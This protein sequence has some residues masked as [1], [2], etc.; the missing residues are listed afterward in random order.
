MDGYL[1]ITGG[2]GD[3]DLQLS[4]SFALLVSDPAG[5]YVLTQKVLCVP[6]ICDRALLLSS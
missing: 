6:H 1:Q 5:S 4:L 3:G 2:H